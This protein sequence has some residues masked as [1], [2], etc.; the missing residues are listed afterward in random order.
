M[1][2]ELAK[3][4]MIISIRNGVELSIEED[5]M[6]KIESLME[7]KRFIKINGRPINTAD[8]VGIFKPEDLD[9]V[10]RRKNGQW[11]DKKGEWHNRG[12]RICPGCGNV[13]PFGKVCGRCQ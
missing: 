7:T 5:K 6:G 9:S 1:T 11:Q 3:K 2:K 13:V 4:L 12:D 10:I 8:I